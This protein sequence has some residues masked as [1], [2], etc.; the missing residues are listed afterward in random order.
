MFVS[1][2]M[3]VAGV[4]MLLVRYGKLQ[5]AFAEGWEEAYQIKPVEK[6]P[7]VRVRALAEDVVEEDVVEEEVISEPVK[8]KTAVKAKAKPKTKIA[9]DKK[10]IAT[11]KSTAKPK[12]PKQ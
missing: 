5:L 11:K 9:V 7:R 2:L 1:L 8:K 12:T 10:K 4:V 3:A 6:S